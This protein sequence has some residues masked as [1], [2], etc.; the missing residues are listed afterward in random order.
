MKNF[1]TIILGVLFTVVLVSCNKD[2]NEDEF[3]TL[4]ATPQEFTA[5]MEKALE[6]RKQQFNL[7]PTDEMKTFISEKGVQI[8]FNKSRI[9]QNENP[10]TG[11]VSID[12]VEIFAKGDM[13]VTNKPTMGH[14]PDGKKA[15]LLSGGEFFIEA[16][17]NGEKVDKKTAINLVVPTNLT[18]SSSENMILWEGA[19][20]EK[21][22]VTWDKKLDEEDNEVI[23]PVKAIEDRG[24]YYPYFDGFGWTNV[25]MFYSDPRPKTTIWATVPEGYSSKNSAVFLSYDGQA[26]ALAKLDTYDTSTKRFS[27]HYGQ[28]PI[29][30]KCHAIFTTADG[31][32]WK[33][34]I[35]SVTITDGGV[36]NFTEADTKTGTETQLVQEMNELP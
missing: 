28:I 29:G 24:D 1:R 27:E 3:E 5:L 12:Y 2:K 7:A 17:H 20:D 22:D 33:Y 19:I 8:T 36:I 31:D 25:D 32:N 6:K 15:L 21:G 10:V 34:A 18:Q 14:L 23:V 16:K 9:T 4:K 11:E 13:I 26:S 35:K 30:L